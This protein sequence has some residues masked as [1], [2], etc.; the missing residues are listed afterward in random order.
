MPPTTPKCPSSPAEVARKW[1]DWYV[2]LLS[3][4]TLD[5]VPCVGGDKGAHNF[6]SLRELSA[7]KRGLWTK[8]LWRDGH[9][10]AREP[11]QRVS[12]FVETEPEHLRSHDCGS[13][14]HCSNAGGGPLP[15]SFTETAG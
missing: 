13:K 11:L 14:S 6:A 4:A 5:G 8:H 2:C 7:K 3:S 1:H 12:M 9:S 10:A 15:K